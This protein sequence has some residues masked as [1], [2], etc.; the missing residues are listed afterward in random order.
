M[1]TEP[2]S[3]TLP[4]GSR[5][6]RDLRSEKLHS[7]L[8]ADAPRMQRGA[9]IREAIAAMQEGSGDSLLIM[10]GERLAGMVTERDVLHKVL[11]RGIDQEAA[12]DGFMEPAP[13]TLTPD[14]T[15]EDVLALMERSGSRT[16]ALVDA[17]GRVAGVI[18]QRDILAFVAE[19]FPE[20]I[21][22]LP[23]RPHQV[24]DTAEGG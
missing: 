21:L 9:S 6:G 13:E 24:A 12:V 19:A 4:G 10:T 8:R 18:R 3:D 23:P 7:L 1:M 20:E 11:A 16:V 5:P 14:H 22:N 15:L 2:A 17:D